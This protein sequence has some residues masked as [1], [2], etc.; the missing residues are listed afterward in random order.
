MASISCCGRARICAYFASSHRGDLRRERLPLVVSAQQKRSALQ[1]PG[2][3]DIELNR[4]AAPVDQR[5]R[6]DAL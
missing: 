4:Y 2:S 6:I 3:W 1:S 5:D